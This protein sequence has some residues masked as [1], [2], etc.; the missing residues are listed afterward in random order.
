MNVYGTMYSVVWVRHD[1][2]YGH[3]EIMDQRYLKDLVQI[4]T[5][6]SQDAASLKTF[7]KRLHSA[8]VTLL[9]LKYVH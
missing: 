7:A 2:V 4:R 3:I 8:V 1:V 5:R 9:K 6:R